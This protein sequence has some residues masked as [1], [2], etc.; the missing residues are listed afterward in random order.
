MNCN[1]VQPCKSVTEI[2]NE[3]LERRGLK[4]PADSD[5][6]DRPRI[7]TKDGHLFV[8]NL[9]DDEEQKAKTKNKERSQ[10]DDIFKHDLHRTGAKC[11]PDGPTDPL[12]AGLLYHNTGLLRLK[13]GRGDGTLSLSCSDKLARWGVLGFQGALLSHYLQKPI[14]FSAVVVGKCPYSHQ[15]MERALNTR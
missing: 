15:A 9:V 7:K 12:Q 4:R 5:L 10:S 8:E 3:E 13:P 1:E 6:E 2:Q 11:V 14:Y